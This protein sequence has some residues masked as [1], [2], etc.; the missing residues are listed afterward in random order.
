MKIKRIIPCLFNKNNYLIRSKN[1]I[2]HQN[3]GNF[4]NQTQRLYNWDPDEIIYINL[5]QNQNNKLEVFNLKTL[6]NISQNCFI[7]FA[8]GGKINSIV[9]VRKLIKNGADKVIINSEIYKKEK[10]VDQIVTEFGSQSLIAAIDYKVINQVPFLHINNGSINAK[11]NIFEWIKI[12]EKLG[13][14]EFFL[15]SIDLDGVGKG[16]DISTINKVLKCTELPVIACGG[17][18][19]KEDFLEAFK[20][21]NIDALGAGNYFNFTENSY[22]NLKLYLKENNIPVR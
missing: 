5:G 2:L 8:I 3:I 19:K 14:G 16:F 4:Y 18:G 10:I 1:F 9:T 11:I 22:P 15:N 7:P 13:V 21:T 12:C 20:K 17:A 6:K